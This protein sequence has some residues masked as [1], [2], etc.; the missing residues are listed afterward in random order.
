VSERD[1]DDLQEMVERATTADG[2]RLA[3]LQAAH[4]ALREALDDDDTQAPG[5]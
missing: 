1:L 3:A 2:D 5:R 4:D